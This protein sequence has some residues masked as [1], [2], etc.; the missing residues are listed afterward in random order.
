MKTEYK[1]SIVK[2]PRWSD[3]RHVKIDID[4]PVV[5]TTGITEQSNSNRVMPMRKMGTFFSLLKRKTKTFKDADI[6]HYW[7]SGYIQL[8]FY[9]KSKAHRN[10]LKPIVKECIEKSGGFQTISEWLEKHEQNKKRPKIFAF[11]GTGSQIRG[12]Q[13]NTSYEYL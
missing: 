12:G 6:S 3:P 8:D 5:D 11:G 9:L 10:A 4:F 7:V 2:Q 13:I 1:I